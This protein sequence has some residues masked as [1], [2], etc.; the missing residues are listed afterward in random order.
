MTSW[1]HDACVCATFSVSLGLFASSVAAEESPEP[2]PSEEIEETS[3]SSEASEDESS[4]ESSAKSSETT[5]DEPSD[6]TAA[7]AEADDEAAST[8]EDDASD[9]SSEETPSAE[10]VM[11]RLDDLYRADASHATMTMVVDK[12]RSKRTLTMESWSKGDERMLVVIREPAREAGTA[13]LRTPDGLWNYLPRADR[14]MRIPSGLLS[15]SWMGSHFSNDD[16]MRETRYDEDYEGRLEAATREDEPIYRLTLTPKP[17]APVVYSKIVFEVTRDDWIPLEQIFYD[18]GDV[19]RRMQFSKVE[20]IGE[21]EIPTR[22]TLRPSDA[23]DAYTSLTY[24]ELEF[25]VDIPESLFSRRG[26]RR[27]AD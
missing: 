2:S 6:G 11:D 19:V 18:D 20:T 1:F 10:A 22:M 23:D 8:G 9:A 17:E 12:P 26:L 3:A 4:S 24:R 14:M 5:A 7:V 13:T 27:K 21:R 25:G 16:L 15:D